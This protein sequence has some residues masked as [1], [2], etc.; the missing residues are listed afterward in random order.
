MSLGSCCEVK[1]PEVFNLHILNLHCFNQIQEE[2]FYTLTWMCLL[3]YF[4]KKKK[5]KLQI[6]VKKF[7]LKS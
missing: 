7:Q 6:W 1:S 5:K 3:V 2:F 4:W